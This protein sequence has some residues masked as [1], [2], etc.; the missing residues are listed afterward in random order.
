[1]SAPPTPCCTI[2]PSNIATWLR[3]N[4]W[5]SPMSHIIM[6]LNVRLFMSRNWSFVRMPRMKDVMSGGRIQLSSKYHTT[7]WQSARQICVSHSGLE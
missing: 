2:T 3:M 5:S 6:D 7:L 1:M 4:S